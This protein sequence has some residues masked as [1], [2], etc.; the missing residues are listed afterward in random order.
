MSHPRSRPSLYE[1]VGRR[2]KAWR[3]AAAVKADA[4]ADRLGLSRAALYRLEKGEIVKVDV[5]ER[6]AA[7]LDVSTASLMGVE[8]EH[9]PGASAFFERM[10]QLEEHTDQIFAHFEPVSFLL[11][12]DEYPKY[13]RTMLLESVPAEIRSDLGSRVMEEIDAVMEILWQRKTQFAGRH[14]HIVSIVGARDIERFLHVGLVGRLSLPR[15]VHAT[16]IEAAKR[17]VLHMAELIE[18]E[19]L[20][21]QIGVVDDTLPSFSFQIFRQRDRE[22][23]AVSPFRIGELPNIR[24]GVATVTASPDAVALYKKMVTDLWERALKGR[25]GARLLR[26]LVQRVGGGQKEGAHIAGIGRVMRCS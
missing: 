15:A 22:Y 14:V 6:I 16:R 11:T 2:L 3:L 4:V 24:T 8:V 25:E 21:V 18:S 13:L 5:L 12:S 20:G 17:E 23:V 7:L 10:R 26:R 1:D 9:Y 19:P